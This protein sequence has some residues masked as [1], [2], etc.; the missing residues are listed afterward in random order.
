[1]SYYDSML[2]IFLRYLA[3]SSSL[4]DGI[5]PD[6]SSAEKITIPKRVIEWSLNLRHWQ[7]PL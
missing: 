3:L 5:V 6:K 7:V 2:P 1:M 4:E